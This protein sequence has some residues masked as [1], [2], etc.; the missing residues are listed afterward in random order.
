LIS[1]SG[2]RVGILLAEPSLP[3]LLSFFYQFY[4]LHDAPQSG[5]DDSTASGGGEICEY[6]RAELLDISSKDECVEAPR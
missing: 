3:L 4:I 6:L 2:V 1:G 5:N